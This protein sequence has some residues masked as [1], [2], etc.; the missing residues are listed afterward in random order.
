MAE[1]TALAPST[2]GAFH[3][4]ISSAP[5]SFELGVDF[6]WGTWTPHAIQ[7]PTLG[8]T[9]PPWEILLAAE[10]EWGSRASAP[11]NQRRVLFDLRKLLDVR[12]RYRVMVYAGHLQKRPDFDD[13]EAAMLR[14][15]DASAHRDADAPLLL[16]GVP[17][18]AGAD[19]LR[20]WCTRLRAGRTER[21]DLRRP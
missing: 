19:L 2:L 18:D 8:P 16:V 14:L 13:L 6:A 17:W 5:R 1:L 10:S 3:R 4:S 15:I 20:A 9:Q 12:A 21:V 11:E 7:D